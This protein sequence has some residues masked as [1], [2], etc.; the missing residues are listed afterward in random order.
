MGGLV[1]MFESFTLNAQHLYKSG[2]FNVAQYRVK[3]N[4]QTLTRHLLQ[5]W[6]PAW[7]C[8][9]SHLSFGEHERLGQL[10]SLGVQLQ[11]WNQ[12][13]V[14]HGVVEPARIGFFSAQDVSAFGIL[15]NN[16]F[17]SRIPSLKGYMCKTLFTNVGLLSNQTDRY[18]LTCRFVVTVWPSHWGGLPP[19]CHWI[20]CC[21]CWQPAGHTNKCQ[22]ARERRT[23]I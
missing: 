18:E 8:I 10:C 6:R 9:L 14:L 13:P 3:T 4:T 11:E 12:V 23:V 17:F 19:W 7:G 2:S 21:Q 5:S 15:G 16:V 1:R 22:R 20:W